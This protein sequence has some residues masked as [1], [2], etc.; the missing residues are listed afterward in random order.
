M[1]VGYSGLPTAE[2]LLRHGAT[3]TV[4]DPKSADD[5]K[6]EVARLRAAGGQLELVLGRHR[7]EDF[8]NADVV[9]KGP[10]IPYSNTYV[11]AALKAG[12]PVE[13]DITIFARNFPGTIAGVTGT[14]GKTTTTTLL[15]EMVRAGGKEVLLGGN[16]RKSPVEGLDESSSD[17][18]AT[19]ELSSFQ[20]EGLEHLKWSPH[21]AVWTNL[22]P[23]HLD[24]YGSLEAYAQAKTHIFAHQRVDDIFVVNA[25]QPQLVELA[26]KA[27]GEVRWFSVRG[28][29]EVG[30]YLRGHELIVVDRSGEQVVGEVASLKLRGEH[31]LGNVLAA[32]AAARALGVRA[33]SIREV[34]ETF[35]GV[36]NRLETVRT[37][38]GVTYVNDTAST[39]PTSAIAALRSFREPVVVIA[40]GHDKQLPLDAFAEE[41][42]ARPHRVVLFD[43]AVGKKLLEVMRRRNDQKARD[44]VL[45]P[46]ASS[47]Q[48]AVDAAR[49]VAPK[50][51]VVLLSPG[52]A[53]FGMFKNEFDRGDQFVAAVKA[54]R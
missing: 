30:A 8:E 19:L 13:S 32:A 53:S 12:V 40:G 10:G 48:A 16:L 24:R 36:D 11:Q 3:V 6:Q 1:G 25:D 4:T 27:P 34:A 37:L 5:L 18:V 50:G 28:P 43:S 31:N 44:L 33:Q 2:W 17:T 54:L 15:S 52:A 29:V 46:L 9:V 45:E 20:L 21:V 14:K 26:K 49:G 41:L 42:L 7:T 47:M 39:I 23:D 51:S 22:F 38:E 35:Q